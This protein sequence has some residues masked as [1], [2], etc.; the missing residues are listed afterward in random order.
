MLI[1]A[2]FKNISNQLSLK[3]N[4]DIPQEGGGGA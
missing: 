2:Y 4:G 3:I 1:L